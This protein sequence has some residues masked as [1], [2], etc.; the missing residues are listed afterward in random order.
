[1]GCLEFVRLSSDRR[2]FAEA[3]C[4]F[5]ASVELAE[6]A[7]DPDELFGDARAEGAGRDV[8]L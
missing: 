8:R 3:W 7:L 2:T 1:M 5:A 6:L 4:R